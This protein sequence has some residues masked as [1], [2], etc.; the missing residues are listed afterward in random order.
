MRKAT[1]QVE[2]K[3]KKILKKSSSFY[4][5]LFDKDLADSAS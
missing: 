1:L 2:T 4:E 3:L 5:A